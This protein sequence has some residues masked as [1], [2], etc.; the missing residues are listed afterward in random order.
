[1]AAS[2]SSDNVK[3][4]GYSKYP[5]NFIIAYGNLANEYASESGLP[6]DCLVKGNPC[7]KDEKKYFKEKTCETVDKSKK[8]AI[9]MGRR[10][11]DAISRKLPGRINIVLSSQYKRESD[12]NGNNDEDLLFLE[13]F[14]IAISYLN[15]RH[16]IESIFIIG[17]MNLWNNIPKEYHVYF[18]KMYITIINTKVLTKKFFTGIEYTFNDFV[19]TIFIKKHFPYENR[20]YKR[21]VFDEYRTGDEIC[22]AYV[23][24]IKE[25]VSENHMKLKYNPLKASSDET[26]YLELLKTVLTSGDYRMDRT[27]VG[28]IATF[29]NMMRFSLKNKKIPIITT[30]RTFV[31]GIIE[32]LLW[33]INGCTD[34][35]K[36]SEKG[37]KI[38][39]G[40]TSKE[41]LS[42][43][44]LDREAGDAGP[45]FVAG[46]PILTDNGYKFIEDVKIEDK[47]YT[48]TG[49]FQ[50]IEKIHNNQYSGEM[51]HIRLGYH[52]YPIVSTPEHPY[53][54]REITVKNRHKDQRN[55]VFYK[56]PTWVPASELIKSKYLVGFKI[57]L[58]EKIPEIN[59]T[60][61][62]NQ[63]MP[64]E[65]YIKKIDN[66]DEW[67]L[68]GYFIGNG[69][70]TKEKTKLGNNHRITFAIPTFKED[71]IVSRIEKILNIKGSVMKSTKKCKKYRVVNSEWF[72]ILSHFG[73]YAYGKK[74]PD[75][76][77]KGPKYLIQEFL[78]GY[79][80]SDGCFE[81]RKEII[82]TVSLDLALSTQ[83]LYLKL[84]YIASVEFQKR[85][86][87]VKWPGK[88]KMIN[89]RNVYS[90]SCIC[91]EKRRSNYTIIKD[92]YIW[93]NIKNIHIEEVENINVYN[94][95]VNTDNTYT[96]LNTTV[97][98]C[99]GFQWRHWGAEYIDKNTYYTGKGFDQLADV[100]K[101]IKENPTDRRLIVSAWNVSDLKKMALPPCHM[102]FQFFVSSEGLSC[103][104]YQRSADVG[105][106]VPFNITSYALLTHM[107]A[108]ICG[109]EANEFVHIM[110][111][112]HIYLNH[113]KPLS[114]QLLNPFNEFPTVEFARPIDNI[115][116]FKYE[117]IKIVG[118]KPV[119]TAIKMEM[120]V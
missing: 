18:N 106:G 55:V 118:Y 3:C 32:E 51:V 95:T 14:E 29:G 37:V 99:Y 97:H 102:M 52:P 83:R 108:H 12:E 21:K 17:G 13:S 104:M 50:S 54:A 96:I 100:I 111:D 42:N 88:E 41:F 101:R 60:R 45:C 66:S 61:Y 25:F 35:T 84:G 114:E 113:I 57:E 69:W 117:D 71:L 8:N 63:H 86:Y 76:I 39:D 40:N 10:T 87:Q 28:T 70:I 105:L 56:K 46:M 98:N 7:L 59:L 75:W 82:T 24:K 93:Y 27:K 22:D 26:N 34:A 120:A 92:D 11:Y 44:G 89:Q 119:N 90:I 65:E 110:G 112:T 91:G 4:T 33:F 81:G 20:T 67:F 38:W 80:E 116:D 68:M 43:L 23:W 30:K 49:K 74:I 79:R 72:Q 5:I 2:S 16:D 15:Y 64:R 1:M 36:L 103:M 78:N 19:N 73:K 48:H 94:F 31:R 9:I 58:E 6:W 47:L 107:I 115:D 85:G 77:H 53:Y 109:L 62:I